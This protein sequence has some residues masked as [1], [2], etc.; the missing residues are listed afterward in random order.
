MGLL[1]PLTF[2]PLSARTPV[3]GRM[4]SCQPSDGWAG[5]RRKELRLSRAGRGCGTRLPG[6]QMQDGAPPSPLRLTMTLSGQVEGPWGKPWL[7][8]TTC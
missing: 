1:F 4:F 7:S 3:S 5:E 8:S 6:L 2:C